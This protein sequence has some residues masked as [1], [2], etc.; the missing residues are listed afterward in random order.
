MDTTQL[1]NSTTEST[2]S[3]LYDFVE[4]MN[5]DLE[6]CLDYCEAQDIVISD[7]VYTVISDLLW[8]KENN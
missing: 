3:L 7:E 2:F 5:P 8:N 4:D 6:M 1:M